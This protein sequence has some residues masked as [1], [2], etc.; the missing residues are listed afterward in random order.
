MSQ[1]TIDKLRSLLMDHHYNRWNKI[2]KIKGM[3][4][5]IHET[6]MMIQRYSTSC[7]ASD[8]N[9]NQYESDL[10]AIKLLIARNK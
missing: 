10:I 7:F 9:K 1:A 3:S 4:T 5:R 6:D 8:K 2:L